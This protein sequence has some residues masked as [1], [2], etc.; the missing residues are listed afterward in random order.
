MHGSNSFAKAI[1]QE[2]DFFRQGGWQY[3]RPCIISVTRNVRR[4]NPV[5]ACEFFHK[6]CRG[7]L[8]YEFL[9]QSDVIVVD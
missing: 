7:Y 1:A 8:M 3:K 5:F 2:V 4:D 6:P 9:P